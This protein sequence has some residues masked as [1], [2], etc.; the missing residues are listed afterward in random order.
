MPITS[1]RMRYKT[2]LKFTSSDL[3]FRSGEFQ[4]GDHGSVLPIRNPLARKALTSFLTHREN[5]GEQQR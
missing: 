4:I 1:G 2:L 5:L 3:L